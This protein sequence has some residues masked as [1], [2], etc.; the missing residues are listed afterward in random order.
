MF[1]G[2]DVTHPAPGTD[3]EGTPSIAAVS[4]WTGEYLNYSA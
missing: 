3:S 2:G 1:I 4:F